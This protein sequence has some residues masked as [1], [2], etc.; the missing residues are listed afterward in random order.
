MKKLALPLSLLLLA[1]CAAMPLRS[2]EV[3][4]Y[5]DLERFMGDWYVIAS[6]PTFIEKDIYN[7]VESYRLADDGS[8]QTTFTF[9]KD[10]IDGEKKT[11]TPVGFIRDTK[12]NAIWGMQFI[13]PFKSDYRIVYLDEDYQVTIIGRQKRDYVWIMARK[14]HID[15]AYYA[16]LAD[17]VEAL[18]YDISKLKKVSQVWNESSD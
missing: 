12:T 2:M 4:D 14:P 18:G 11:Y 16:R 6:I 9:R 1:G 15:E 17:K 7:A 5:V 13:W 8:I 3:V 10:A